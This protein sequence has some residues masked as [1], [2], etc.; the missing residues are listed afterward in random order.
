MRLSAFIHFSQT[1]PVTLS[2]PVASSPV[3][4]APVP[5][6]ESAAVPSS[7][8]WACASCTLENPVGSVACDACGTPN[9]QTPSTNF[10]FLFLRYSFESRLNPYRLYYL[11]CLPNHQRYSVAVALVS[12]EARPIHSVYLPCPRPWYYF[13]LFDFLLKIICFELFLLFENPFERIRSDSPSHAESVPVHVTTCL[14]W[15]TFSPS[16]AD[17]VSASP[18][19]WYLQSFRC[20]AGGTLRCSP[21]VLWYG[22]VC[23]QL[24]SVSLSF[25][26]CSCFFWFFSSRSQ[27]CCFSAFGPA[28]LPLWCQSI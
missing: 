12:V 13:K 24:I 1:P 18:L 21:A 14:F 6:V 8:I 2:K 9:P 15:R 28:G 5:F 26:F 20:N 27:C 16:D 4:A 22:S 3:A 7:G 11:Q 19:V 17:S 25:F 10:H 23:F